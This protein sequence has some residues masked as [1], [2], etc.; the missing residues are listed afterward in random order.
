[1][2]DDEIRNAWLFGVA[3]MFDAQPAFVLPLFAEIGTEE[4][5]LMQDVSQDG[6]IRS[7]LLTDFTD[8]SIIKLNNPLIREV[9]QLALLAFEDLDGRMHIDERAP[10]RDKLQNFIS[11]QRLEAHPFMKAVIANFC[12]DAQT[13]LEAELAA[14]KSLGGAP[15]TQSYYQRNVLMRERIKRAFE[16][17]GQGTKRPSFRLLDGE[18]GLHVELPAGSTQEDLTFMRAAVSQSESDLATLSSVAQFVWECAIATE[19]SDM[20]ES[21]ETGELMY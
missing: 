5:F 19:V 13:A 8:L 3:R 17:E 7:F 16:V 12:N 9:G 15:R 18:K 10:L 4:P 11:D 6:T 2:L 20:F 21:D 1:M 14:I